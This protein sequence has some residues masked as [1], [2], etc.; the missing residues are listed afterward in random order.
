MKKPSLSELIAPESITSF[1]EIYWPG[2]V[3]VSHGPKASLKTICELP[4]LQSLETLLH[5][6]P[7]TVQA[8]LP[9]VSDESSSISASA[10]DAGKLFKNGMGLLFNN[11]HH[12][13]PV[14]GEWLGGMSR[15]LGLPRSTHG[16]CMLYATPAG[17][18]TAPH[19]DQNINF[20]VQLHGE[21]TWWLAP[22]ASVDHP[23]ERHTL[24][25]PLDPVLAT[26]SHS[27][28]PA[29]MPSGAEKIVLRAGSVLFVPRGYWH[30]T[31]AQTEA[32]ALNFTY[33]QPTWVDILTLALRSRLLLAPE[34][35]EL[36]DGVNSSD[37]SRRHIAQEKFEML[38]IEL[39]A[40]LPNWQA[41]DI[42]AATEGDG[43]CDY[44]GLSQ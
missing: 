34:W 41:S 43:E 12:F 31:E 18:G 20:V 28:M 3:F 33:S 27:E 42:L 44:E 10:K 13:S 23:T 39:V 40:D 36:A 21:K 8:H 14:L 16:R 15:D 22:N 6:W 4:F 30:R 17:R 1:L 32:L 26:Y 2:R 5:A 24:G 29:E 7:E 19:F 38:L 35:R 9:D 11:A 37:P 25:Q